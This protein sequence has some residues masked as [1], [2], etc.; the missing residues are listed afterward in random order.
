MNLRVNGSK[1]ALRALAIAVAV[2]CA[3]SASPALA[4]AKKGLVKAAPTKAT[5]V[6][7]GMPGSGK[8]FVTARLAEKLKLS[9]PLVSGDIVREAIGKTNSPAE[10]A[11]RALQVSKQF[12]KTKGEIG[13]RMAAKTAAQKSKVVIVEG[14]RSPHDFRAFRKAYPKVILVAVDVPTTLRHKR[15][16]ARGRAGED[17]DAY[18]AQR[19]KYE[20]SVGV[21]KLMKSAD[22]H[23]NV[24]SN[25]VKALDR[26][27]EKVS[28]ALQ[29]VD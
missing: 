16:L 11:Q 13:R 19:D 15:M 7:V 14:F 4:L 17:N 5:V 23:L 12:V 26:E 29:Q 18:L 22:V 25:N 8:T 21:D 20:I 24:K 27:L 6:F 10:Q 2:S 3:L 9:K 1:A 28:R